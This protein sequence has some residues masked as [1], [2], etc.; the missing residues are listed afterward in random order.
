MAEVPAQA[1]DVRGVDPP[2]YRR[3]PARVDRRLNADSE[4]IIPAGCRDSRCRSRTGSEPNIGN[5]IETERLRQRPEMLAGHPVLTVSNT[6]TGPALRRSMEEIGTER[7]GSAGG[8]IFPTERENPDLLLLCA[9]RGVLPSLNKFIR[10]HVSH[11][12]NCSPFSR[13]CQGYWRRCEATNRILA[14]LLPPAH[15]VP[16]PAIATLTR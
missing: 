11:P 10:I 7:P 16:L 13:D 2:V 12:S 15:P 9:L 8:A 14:R 4:P 6:F 1:A 3:C 5:E